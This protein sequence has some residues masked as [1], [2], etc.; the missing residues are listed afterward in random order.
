MIGLLL[1]NDG[2]GTTSVVPKIAQR[3]GGFSREAAE[4]RS[5]RTAEGGRPHVDRADAVAKL[6]PSAALR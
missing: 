1:G 5:A 3:D 4:L 6:T 2:K